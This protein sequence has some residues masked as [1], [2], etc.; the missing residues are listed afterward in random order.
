MSWSNNIKYMDH[1]QEDVKRLELMVKKIAQ[2]ITP[3]NTGIQVNL[4]QIIIQL[5]QDHHPIM[6]VTL[7]L[8]KKNQDVVG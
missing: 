1:V 2:N 8:R 7:F 3:T 5:W 4:S 6:V